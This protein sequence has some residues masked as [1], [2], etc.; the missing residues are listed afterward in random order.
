[1]VPLRW[2]GHCFPL[3]YSQVERHA[4]S[5]ILPAGGVGQA[6]HHRPDW[7][8]CQDVPF[9]LL[10]MEHLRLFASWAGRKLWREERSWEHCLSSN[11][12]RK[13]LLCG[14]DWCGLLLPLQCLHTAQKCSPAVPYGGQIPHIKVVA[15]SSSWRLRQDWPLGFGCH[16]PSSAPGPSPPV[17]P[18]SS[19]TWPYC[20][21]YEHLAHWIVW[22]NLPNLKTLAWSH[23]QRCFCI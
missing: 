18:G 14:G 3:I 12:S 22:D 10:L 4:R 9:H 19:G 11:S 23:Q 7:N 8:P 6:S 13:R 17:V 15:G 20:P 5:H 1:M 2:A 21:S 16:W